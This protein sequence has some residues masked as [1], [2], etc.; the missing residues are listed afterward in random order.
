MLVPLSIVYLSII[1]YSFRA[2]TFDS[3]SRNQKGRFGLY[4][5]VLLLAWSMI[6]V[7]LIAIPSENKTLQFL[8]TNGV[9]NLYMFII[10]YFFEPYSEDDF[11]YENEDKVVESE[12]DHDSDRDAR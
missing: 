2:F 10:S 8:N 3:N 12:S 7:V 1:F 6:T 9:V 5:S 4:A 11:T